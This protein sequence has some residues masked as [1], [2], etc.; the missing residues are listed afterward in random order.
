MKLLT[1]SCVI[2][3]VVAITAPAAASEALIKKARCVAC[4]A[5]DRKMVGPAYKD[6]AVKYK[7][8]PEA[9][10]R[11][12]AKVRAGGGGVWGDIP[13]PPNPPERISVADLAAVIDW[14]LK[15]AQN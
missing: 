7:D 9:A 6:V 10:A 5:I 13:M 8:Q 2:A 15:L 4:H 14:V 11:L 3:A 12:A 1:T